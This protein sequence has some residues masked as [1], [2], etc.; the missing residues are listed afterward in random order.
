MNVF[1]LGGT[2]NQK[3]NSN[4]VCS[5]RSFSGGFFFDRLRPGALEI[6]RYL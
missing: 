5:C 2:G 4:K 1:F 3:N 6:Y